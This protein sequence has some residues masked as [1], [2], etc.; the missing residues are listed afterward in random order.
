M[1]FLELL[2][3]V[4]LIAWLVGAVALPVGS[5][6]ILGVLV[7]LVFVRLLQGRA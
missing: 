2:V 1:G 6:L 4:L 3:V 7:G 5:S